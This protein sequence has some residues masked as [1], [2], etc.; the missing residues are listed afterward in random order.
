MMMMMMNIKKHGPGM[1]CNLDLNKHER[2][3][4]PGI[5]TPTSVLIVFIYRGHS[6]KIFTWNNSFIL[7]TPAQGRYRYS[8]HITDDTTEEQRG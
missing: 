8:L 1:F 3:E 2:S 4:E 6:S 5:L 7:H